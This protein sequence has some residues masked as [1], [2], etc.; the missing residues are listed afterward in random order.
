MPE[1]NKVCFCEDCGKSFHSFNFSED[2]SNC[3]DGS[4]EIEMEWEYEPS[5]RRCGFCKGTGS[6]VYVVT[7]RCRPCQEHYIYDD[8]NDD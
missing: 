7:K 5:I 4:V 1:L 2:C 3:D 8:E 6:I